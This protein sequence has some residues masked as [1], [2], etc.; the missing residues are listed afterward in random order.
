MSGDTQ[1][2]EASSVDDAEE[3]RGYTVNASITVGGSVHVYATSP[4]AALQEAMDMD[5]RDF[6]I[7]MGTAEVEFNIDPT[8]EV[9]R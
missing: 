4:E 8:V 6:D 1:N 5:G 7:D 2:Q 9:D 3:E